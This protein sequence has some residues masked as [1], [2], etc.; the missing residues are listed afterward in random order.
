MIVSVITNNLILMWVAI[1]ATT[2]SSAF[3]VGTYKQKTSLEAAWKYIIICSVGVAFGL[4]G[5]LLTFANANGVLADPSQA[6]FWSAVNQQATGLNPMLMYIAFAFVLIGFGTKCGLFPMHTW[7]SDAHSEAPSPVSAI[8]SAVLLNCA[9]LVVLR[10]YTLVSKAVGAEFPQTLMLIFGLLSVLVA[11]LFII[12]QFD[13]K[14]LLAYSSIEN[15]GLISFAFGLGGPIG[16]FAGLLHTINH[17]L[18]K[19]LLFCASGNILLKYKTRDMNQVR[20]LWRVA[21]VSAVLFAG[22][23]LALGGIPPF[24]VFVSEFSVVVAGITAGKTWLVILCL[25]LLTIV[26]AGLALMLLKT[27]LGKQPD[28]VEAGEVSKVS[29]AAMAILL[30]LMFVMG[31][32]IAEPILQLLKSAVGI[33]L[34]SEHVS[35]GDM[36]VLPWQSLAK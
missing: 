9:M 8:L 2:L 35:F 23:A 20:G 31:I 30:L 12:V 22:G 36:L 19:T 17:S 21:P 6:I 13:I 14:R 32:H 28:N 5:T 15:M 11:A 7:L 18:A 24:N 25:I 10:Y 33:V 4:Y 26:L 16:V 29:L 1:E 34:G 27:V 3:L